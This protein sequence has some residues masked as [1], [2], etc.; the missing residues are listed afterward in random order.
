[1]VGWCGGVGCLVG[2]PGRLVGGLVG[3]VY[4]FVC[5]VGWL[6]MVGC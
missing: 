5:V 1:M 4:V 3:W 2:W 6:V